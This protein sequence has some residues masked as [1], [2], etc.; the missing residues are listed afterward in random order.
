MSIRIDKITSGKFGNQIL[1][2]NSLM[3][4]SF[5]Y[6]IIPS[7]CDWK[8][9][10]FFKEIVS[11]IPSKKNKKLLFCK[12]LIENQN[13]DF[14]NYDYILDD[15]ANCLHNIFFYITKTNP[16]DFLKL[17][18]E[19][20]PIL[21]DNIIYIGIHF[22]GRDIISSDGNCGREIHEFE[23]YKNSIDYIIN[24]K[25]NNNNYLFIMCSDDINFNSFIKTLNYLKS[26]NYNYKLGPS[27]SNQNNNFI[28]DWA[29]LS[30]CDILINS[31][32]TFC[33]TASFIGKKNKFIIHSLE[34]INKNKN[35]T[36]WNNNVNGKIQEYNIVEFRHTFDNFWI[37]ILNNN[38]YY[39]CNILI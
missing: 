20:K 1:Q 8:N 35:H 24:N 39:Y 13:L 38:N 12:K 25:I 17:K 23:Y 18:D 29:F 2:Y 32:S 14:K 31:S 6:N 7:C 22:R 10:I 36:N 16:R 27:T 21:H 9:G 28:Y 11:Y 15:P 30:E 19:F 4:I 37:D 3:Q 5:N 33:M 34:W 26:K